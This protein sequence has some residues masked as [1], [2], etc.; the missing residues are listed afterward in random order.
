[1][2]SSPLWGFFYLISFMYSITLSRTVVLVPSLEILLFN[3]IM[4][5]VIAEKEA[6]FSSPLWG[7]F[8]LMCSVKD[9]Q[10]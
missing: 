9:E 5:L 6:L 4:I 10:W 1:M 3:K 2:F 8:Y 7:F